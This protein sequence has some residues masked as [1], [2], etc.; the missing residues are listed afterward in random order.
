[1]NGK[2]KECGEKQIVIGYATKNLR[3]TYKFLHLV[4]KAIHTSRDVTWLPFK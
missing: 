1:M 4:T 2:W 3:G